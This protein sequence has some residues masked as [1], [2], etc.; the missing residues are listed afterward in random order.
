MHQVITLEE[1]ILVIKLDYGFKSE[2]L[3]VHVED[4]GQSFL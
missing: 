4:D 1:T 3:C 2:N